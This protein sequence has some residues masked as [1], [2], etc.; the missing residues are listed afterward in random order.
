MLYIVEIGFTLTSA[1]EVFRS[2]VGFAADFATG[3]STGFDQQTDNWRGN[4]AI[5]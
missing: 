5:F 4:R 3:F 1:R 2:Y